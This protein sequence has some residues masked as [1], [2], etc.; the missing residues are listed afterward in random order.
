VVASEESK[1]EFLKSSEAVEQRLQQQPGCTVQLC[2]W[3]LDCVVNYAVPSAA[4]CT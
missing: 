2:T 3:V 1:T 4:T